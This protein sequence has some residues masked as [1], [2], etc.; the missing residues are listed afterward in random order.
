DVFAAGQRHAGLIQFGDAGAKPG[1]H[2]ELAQGFLNER[3]R[4]FAHVGSNC[5]V[6]LDD[7]DP[8]LGLLAKDPTKPRGHLRRRLD[9]GEPAACNNDRVAAVL[10]RPIRQTVQMPVEGDRVSE[11]VNA[12]AMPGETRDLWTGEPAAG[13]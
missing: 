6:P 4:A 2:T 7:D 12:E 11:L 10:C 1:L 5:A 13:S 9:A 8:R 3:P